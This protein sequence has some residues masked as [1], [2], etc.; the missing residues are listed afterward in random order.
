MKKVRKLLSLVLS[1]LFL[2]TVGAALVACP[3]PDPDPGED[4]VPTTCK[5]TVED[6]DTTKGTVTLSPAKAEYALGE[7][8]TISIEAKTGYEIQAVYI[9]TRNYTDTLRNGSNEFTT[10]SRDWYADKDTTVTV[11]F[12]EYGIWKSEDYKYSLDVG[13]YNTTKGSVTVNPDRA[14]YAED[15][16]VTVTITTSNGSTLKTFEVNGVDKK[17]NV[18]FDGNYTYTYTLVITGNTVLNIVLDDD[19]TKIYIFEPSS[20]N[21]NS[22]QRLAEFEAFIKREGKVLIDFYGTECYYCN[23]LQGEFEEHITALQAND[24]AALA[25]DVKIVK[26]NVS[27]TSYLDPS[28]PNY[29]IY[30][31]Y[32]RYSNGGLPY[33]VMVED[34]GIDVNDNDGDI[35][36]VV[37]GAYSTYAQLL[38]WMRN[39]TFEI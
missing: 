26:V 1:M 8:V 36:G 34:D 21:I 38:S 29:P 25:A 10:T 27:A 23:V 32:S 24:A 35:I 7:K 6:Y 37:N 5:L 2:V 9:G 12:Q 39:P 33:V 14:M 28:S 22:Q 20:N 30:Q 18:V 11:R 13:T 31:K 4:P 3:Q 17:A 15:E 16:E 19:L